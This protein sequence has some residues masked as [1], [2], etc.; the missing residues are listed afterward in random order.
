MTRASHNTASVV[1][2]SQINHSRKNGSGGS[3]PTW[4][5]TLEE[6]Y[7]KLH[8]K[9]TENSVGYGRF[10]SCV[11]RTVHDARLSQALLRYKDL[12]AQRNSL[13]SKSATKLCE[14][15]NYNETGNIPKEIEKQ[16]DLNQYLDSD[17]AIGSNNE[18]TENCEKHEN[19]RAPSP[20]NDENM[21]LNLDEA[22]LVQNDT[23]VEENDE[24]NPEVQSTSSDKNR[25]IEELRTAD[26]SDT[27]VISVDKTKTE[28]IS[29]SDILNANKY[30]RKNLKTSVSRTSKV[31]SKSCPTNSQA[32]NLEK[33]QQRRLLLSRSKSANRQARM[34]TPMS[35]EAKHAITETIH[36]MQHSSRDRN[37]NG[38]VNFVP[39]GGRKC[40]KT[41]IVPKR[42]QS[43][44]DVS[45]V[46]ENAS[47]CL[48]TL[49]SDGVNFNGN[50]SENENESCHS[51]GSFPA[52]A[53]KMN[54]L[55][56][57]IQ[58]GSARDRNP[59][60]NSSYR[61]P[62]IGK[63][64]I[65]HDDPTFEITPPGFDIRYK[66]IEIKEERESETP[67]P[68]IRKRAIDKCS[69]WLTKYNK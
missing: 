59:T 69:E 11:G 64:D 50:D 28:I 17:L 44:V 68:D 2:M 62:G 39:T 61:L 31:T 20:E 22:E 27:N 37:K 13:K 14:I 24:N 33:Y 41:W 1:R 12:A 7:Q 34:F 49:K 3:Y 65:A 54:S 40:V 36:E 42:T 57:D 4:M 58:Q 67:P 47:Q 26:V 35:Q 38:E 25:T 15:N 43:S 16:T 55:L 5:R 66:D 32:R 52:D 56:P 23:S 29:D 21:R 46:L 18:E 9:I 60:R 48:E 63:Y 8:K 45:K 53:Q 19:Y 6:K 30:C 51:S 10:N